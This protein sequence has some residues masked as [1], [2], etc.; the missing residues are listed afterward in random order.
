MI[1]AHPTRP[2]KLEEAVTTPDG[3]GGYSQSWQEIGVLWVGLHGAG[4]SA[5]HDGIGPEGRLRLR[6][7]TRAAPQGS[8]RRPRPDQRLR[9]GGR[10]FRLLAVT[11]ADAGGAWLV[12]HAIEEVPT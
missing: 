10:I 8:P 3:T 5:G 12:C 9:D 6:L 2:M 11:E 4:A 1:P 7:Y